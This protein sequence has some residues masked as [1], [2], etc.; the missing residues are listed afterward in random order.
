MLRRVLVAAIALSSF[1]EL[2]AQTNQG[3]W[4]IESV[5]GVWEVQEAK[6]PRRPM[7]RTDVLIAGS[8]IHC[9]TTPVASCK[10]TYASEGTAK[11][12]PIK[13]PPA[14]GWIILGQP[15]HPPAP[16]RANELQEIVVNVGV[17]GGRR[18]DSPVCS[19]GLPLLAPSCGELLDPQGFTLQWTPRATEKGKTFTVLAGGADS[20][21]R[22]RWNAIAADAGPVH[23]QSPDDS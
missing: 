1:C 9:I 11:P 6:A 18:K 12:F 13:T 2:N 4:I 16:K 7:G 8:K 14:Q 15:P 19:G 22:R 17:R 10:L 21:E 5:E 23:T 20:S 3:V